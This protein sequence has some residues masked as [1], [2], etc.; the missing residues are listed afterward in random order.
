MRRMASFSESRRKDIRLRTFV[1]ESKKQ[2][3]DQVVRQGRDM[4]RDQDGV[5]RILH[6]THR[7]DSGLARPRDHAKTKRAH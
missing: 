1:L 2:V 5:S 3:L 6:A 7:G 4:R